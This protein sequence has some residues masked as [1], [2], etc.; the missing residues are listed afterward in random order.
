MFRPVTGWNALIPNVEAI[1]DHIHRAFEGF[2]TARP[3]PVE[4]EIPTDVL[5]QSGTAGMLP[6]AQRLRRGANPED[7]EARQPCW[8]QPDGRSSGREGG[9]LFRR[10]CRTAA[11]GGN[12]RA[13]VTTSYGGKGSI[14]DDHP[15]ALDAPSAQGVRQEPCLRLRGRMRSGTGR[16]SEPAIQ[17]NCRH[18]AQATGEAHP[19]RHRRERVRQE[20]PGHGHTHRRRQGNPGPARLVSQ[21]QRLSTAQGFDREIRQLR[22]R[23]AQSLRESGANQQRVMDT[24]R[25]TL[26]RD[27][28][29]VADPTMAAYWATRGMPCYGPRTYVAPHGWTSIGFAFPAALGR[30]W[31]GRTGKWLSSPGTAAGNSICRSLGTAAQYGINVVVLLFNDGAWGVLRDRQRDYFGGRYY[32]TNLKNPDFVKL[33]GAYGLPATRVDNCDELSRALA[34]ALAANSFH[35][36]EVRTPHGFDQFV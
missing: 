13:P 36:I 31:H 18:G 6:A 22:Q 3:R 2:L 28:I 19:H 14:P 21:R 17:D 27:A 26:A 15:L 9:D 12:A 24:I 11:T 23:I 29:V 34:D 10:D 4:L 1:P 30:R 7:V 8:R 20:L 32:A 16:G 5:G 33:A 25:H 35:L